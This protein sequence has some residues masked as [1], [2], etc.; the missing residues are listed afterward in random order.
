MH[1]AP[2]DPSS[3]KP[4]DEA[5]GALVRTHA[6]RYRATAALRSG[7]GA[8][9]A[10]L[11]ASRSSH[12]AGTA[13]AATPARPAARSPWRWWFG[14]AAGGALATALLMG[15]V[16]A[17]ALRAPDDGLAGEVLANHLRS[18][19]V[20]HLAD[21]ASTDQHTV[22]PWFQGKLGYA[23]PVEDFA[24][25]GFVLSGGRLDYVAGQPV[26]ALVYK[27]RNHVVNLFVWPDDT[28]AEAAAPAR[29]HGF[30]LLRWRAAG[31]TF[32]AVSDTGASE[33]ET[34]AGL[35]KQRLPTHPD[36]R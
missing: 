35:W 15:L 28:V 16:V 23:P 26:A 30:Q 24:A 27:R 29:R 5:L 8:E 19:M 36:K 6:T 1:N 13:A 18:L 11:S 4:D 12:G 17:P 21:V 14:G 33:L 34:F 25:D 7:V 9:I 20:D 2:E 10:L 3:S 32:W 22:K 31:M